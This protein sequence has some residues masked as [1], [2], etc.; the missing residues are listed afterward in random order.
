[1][2]LSDLFKSGGSGSIWKHFIHPDFRQRRH[3]FAILVT[4]ILAIVITVGALSP[5]NLP[6]GP[7][8]SDKLHHFLAFATLVFPASLIFPRAMIY[9]L[10]G[11]VLLGGLIEVVQPSVGRHGEFVDFAAD[12]GGVGIGVLLGSV[13]RSIVKAYIR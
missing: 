13:F 7:P 5:I 4:T 3:G 10:P 9:V 6:Q 1:M 2:G 12:L 11:A 8:G